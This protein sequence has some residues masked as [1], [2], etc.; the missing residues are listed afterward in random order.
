MAKIVS[1]PDSAYEALV[2]GMEIIHPVNLVDK[3]SYMTTYEWEKFDL[4]GWR[5]WVGKNWHFTIYT[6]I[7]YV[8]FIF[9][10]QYL[11]RD[12][13]PFKLTGILTTWN[14]ILAVFSIVA[15]LRTVPEFI[16]VISSPNGFHNSVCHW[17]EKNESISIL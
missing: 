3:P 9:T 11:M 8:I 12:R 16:H 15:F 10:T 6:S 1:Y 14:S 2:G 4:N 13:K 7:A 17:Y 5:R